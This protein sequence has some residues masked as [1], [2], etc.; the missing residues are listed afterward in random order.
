MRR[1][2][3]AMMLL[4]AAPAAAAQTT[5][6]V[7]GDS[8]SAAYGLDPADG[9]VALLRKRLAARG[10]DAGVVNASISGDTTRG[11]RAR[12]PKA[13]E[14][15]DPDVVI[16]E[17][18]GNDGLRGL[19]LAETRR[20]LEAMVERARQAGARVL[21]IG[22]RL[23]SNYGAA[24]IERFQQVFRDVASGADVPLVPKLLA[25]VGE[26]PELMQA[27]GIHPNAQAQPRLL[28]NVWP[29]LAPLLGADAGGGD[30]AGSG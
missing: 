15:H 16:I 23:P 14:T 28:D 9:W 10:I 3:L 8:L 7:V 6:L 5:I 22:V 1:L 29:A 2:L 11:G 19:P 24:F 25:G 18:G 20:N 26:R 30:A 12:L 27:D 4:A 21:L 13:L 17:L